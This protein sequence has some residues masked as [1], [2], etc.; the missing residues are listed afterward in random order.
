MASEKSRTSDFQPGDVVRLKSGGP[1]M[2]VH[3]ISEHEIKCVWID[4]NKKYQE[5]FGPHLLIGEDD[6]PTPIMGGYADD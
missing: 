5:S 1:A 6:G 4:G 2:T 3:E